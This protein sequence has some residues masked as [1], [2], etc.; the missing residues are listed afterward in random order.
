MPSPSWSFRASLGQT[1]QTSP[2]AS[3]SALAWFVFATTGQLSF[4]PVLGGLNTAA[5]QI[6]SVSWSL[7]A[8]WGQ[9]SQPSPAAS[10]SALAW[11]VFETVGQ[12]SFPPILG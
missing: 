4:P 2:E 3:A 11:F 8:S 7:R 9:P 1:S 12:L 6:T 10:A 5:A